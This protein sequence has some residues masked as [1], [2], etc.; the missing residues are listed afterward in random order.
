MSQMQIKGTCDLPSG[1]GVLIAGDLTVS[2][3]CTNKQW[4]ITLDARALFNGPLKISA[5]PSFPIN[6][7]PSPS[8]TL[9]RLGSMKIL[10]IAR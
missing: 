4:S 1:V 8:I 2:A 5:T 7:L 3:N 9:Q 6:G 10:D